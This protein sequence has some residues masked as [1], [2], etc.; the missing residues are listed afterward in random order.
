ME[1]NQYTREDLMKLGIYDL[2]EIGRKVGVPSP[3]AL[4]KGELIDYIVGIIYGTI[5]KKSNGNL[6]GRPTRSGQK[7]YQKF[8]DLIDKVESPKVSSTFIDV[9]D[10]D[11]DRSFSYLGALSMKVASPKEEYVNDAEQDNELTLKKGVVCRVGDQFVARKLKF[12]DNLYDAK[13]SDE[14]ASHYGVQEDDI[15]EYLLGEYN[16][17]AQIIKVNDEFVSLEKVNSEKVKTSE[18]CKEV[19]ISSGVKI[20]TQTSSL[21]YAPSGVEREEMIEKAEKAFEEIGYSIVKICYDRIAPQIGA[22]R[23]HKKSEFYAESVGDE[24]ETIEMT[25]AGVERAKFYASLGYKTVILID[26][27]SWLIS[28]LETYPASIYGN[29]VSKIAKLPK[30]DAITVVCFSGHMSN[31]KVKQLSNCFDDM[32]GE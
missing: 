5:E 29:F 1:T 20:Q 2:R 28:V 25:E 7:T 26:N 24:Y 21:V 16:Q 30:G 13:I 9:D 14:L 6:R 10:A 31:E 27:L 19:M 32:L 4:K 15:I 12:V 3:T 22:S 18:S 17:V 8:V 11:F 23:T